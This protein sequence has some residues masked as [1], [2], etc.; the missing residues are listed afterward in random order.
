MVE[1]GHM[2]I[3]TLSSGP[4]RAVS[5]HIYS[6]AETLLSSYCKGD[7]PYSTC[8]LIMQQQLGAKFFFPSPIRKDQYTKHLQD[9]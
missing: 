9:L 2:M 8:S 3:S 4:E 5:K 7:R 6:E 1:Y